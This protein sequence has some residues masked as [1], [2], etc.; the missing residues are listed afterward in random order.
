[1]KRLYFLFIFLLLPL[2]VQAAEAV[3]PTDSQSKQQ[4]QQEQKKSVT[5]QP[6]RLTPPPPVHKQFQPTERIEADTVIA[7]PADI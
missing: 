4:S 2:S 1:M 3:E 5:S 6:V 7:F